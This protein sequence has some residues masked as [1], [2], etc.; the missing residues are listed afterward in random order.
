[1][2]VSTAMHNSGEVFDRQPCHRN[3]RVSILKRLMNWLVGNVDKE[4]LI[5]WLYGDAGSGKSTVAQTLAMQSFQK[6]YLL[7][8]F[9]F[10]K[11][12]HQRST[13]KHLVATIAYQA[14]TAVPALKRL[15]SAAVEH[16]PLIFEKSLG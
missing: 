8:S 14:A 15:I 7:G 13:F 16:D 2:V 12:D 6:K 9:F 10:S 5:M 3:T 4:G 1:M 11:T